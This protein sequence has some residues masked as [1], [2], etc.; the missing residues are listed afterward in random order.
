[1]ARK[2]S[3]FQRLELTVGTRWNFL[4]FPTVPTIPSGILLVNTT[5]LMFPKPP[6]LSK[7]SLPCRGIPLENG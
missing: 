2:I 6:R 7:G 5:G 4:V 1:M 3:I